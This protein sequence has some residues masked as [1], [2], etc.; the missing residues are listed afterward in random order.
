MEARA[1]DPIWRLIQRAANELPTPFT[2]A[3]MLTW[4][5]ENDLEV[6]PAT[7]R[8]HMSA[9]AGNSSTYLVHPTFRRR[10]PILW[11]VGRGTYEPYDA[12]VHG[13]P[14]V[15]ESE[16]L[17]V[18]DDFGESQLPVWRPIERVAEELP[19]PF[20]VQEVL[21]WCAEHQPDV[22]PATIRAHMSAMAGNS[23]AYLVHPTFSRRP[24]IL[25]RLGRGTY[26]PYDP[27]R[28]GPV[29]TVGPDVEEEPEDAVDAAQEFVLEQYLEDFLSTVLLAR[30]GSP[31]AGGRRSPAG[32]QTKSSRRG[33]RARS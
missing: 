8:A 6:A 33:C 23:N 26:E 10:P 5:E 27:R 25:W 29:S 24:P 31:A 9:L 20:T 17:G 4:C 12:T 7:L 22:L 1:Q 19:S 21:D 13:E 16:G 14:G 30:S 28:H 18:D 2:A 15:D 32:D 11:P 3:D